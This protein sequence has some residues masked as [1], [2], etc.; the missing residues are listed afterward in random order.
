LAQALYRRGLQLGK[1]GALGAVEQFG[2]GEVAARSDHQM[3]V[4]VRVAIEH[5]DRERS[6]PQHQAAAALTDTEL[7]ETEDASARRSTGDGAQ[8]GRAPGRP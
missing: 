7:A 2:R 3:A 8:V 5:H 4:V 6:R 1:R